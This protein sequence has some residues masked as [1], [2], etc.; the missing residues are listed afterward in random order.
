MKEELLK[1][2]EGSDMVSLE[3]VAKWIDHYR[4]EIH[5]KSGINQANKVARVAKEWV[6]WNTKQV[7]GGNFAT[8]FAETFKAETK[9]AWKNYLI[10]K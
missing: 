4:G 1:A 10:S 7:D 3:A 2:F 9:R 5:K 8:C 6:R